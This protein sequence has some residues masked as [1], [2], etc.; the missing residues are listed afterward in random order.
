M[1]TSVSENIPASLRG[2]VVLEKDQLKDATTDLFED[3][4][5]KKQAEQSHSLAAKRQ[6][7]KDSGNIIQLGIPIAREVLLE[8][9]PEDT[10]LNVNSSSTHVQE[11]GDK[12]RIQPPTHQQNKGPTTDK[13]TGNEWDETL[14]ANMPELELDS[15]FDME[16]FERDSGLDG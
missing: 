3:P 13:V 6:Q 9:D 14:M 5:K 10:T 12:S 15:F 16:A 11:G 2:F 8:E 4:A 7:E 1:L